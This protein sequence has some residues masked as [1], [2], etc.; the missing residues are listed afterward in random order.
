MFLPQLQA[1]RNGRSLLI[2]GELWDGE[3]SGRER[4]KRFASDNHWQ[5]I[6]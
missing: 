6:L 5:R 4:R 1:P 3:K 2:F